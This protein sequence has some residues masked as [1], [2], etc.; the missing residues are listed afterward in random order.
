MQFGREWTKFAVRFREVSGLE[1][2]RLERVN[3]IGKHSFSTFF[4]L[5]KFV[6][7]VNPGDETHDNSWS[8]GIPTFVNMLSEISTAVRNTV[9][10]FA[11]F[12]V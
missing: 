7:N 1:S 5:T 8:R 2:V 12:S 9:D 6:F 11:L 3:C 10:E 4:A